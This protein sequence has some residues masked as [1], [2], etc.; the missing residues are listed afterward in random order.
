MIRVAACLTMRYEEHG[1]CPQCGE[2]LL[3]TEV[4][5]KPGCCLCTA[6]DWMWGHL[7]DGEPVSVS[8]PWD[9]DYWSVVRKSLAST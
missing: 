4:I 6:C 5:G 8:M 1:G 3:L 9:F 7:V 2:H